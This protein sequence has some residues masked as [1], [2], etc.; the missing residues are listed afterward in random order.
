MPTRPVARKLPP[1]F[2]LTP[3]VSDALQ[4]HH[5]I[6]ALESTVVTHG[7]PHPEN[8]ALAR[9]METQVRE[10]GSIPAT[11]AVMEG[12]VRVGLTDTQLQ[13]LATAPHPRKIS[14]RDFAPALVQQAIGGTTVAG[15]LFAANQA[16]ICIFATGGIG[17]VHRFPAYDISTDLPLLASTPVVVVCAG[18]KAILDLPGTLEYLETVGVPVVGYQTDEFPAFYSQESGFPV[19]ARADSPEEI[20]AI[21]NTHWT[22]GFKSALLV[23]APPP[24]EIALPQSQVEGAIEQALEEAREKNVRGQAIT[25]FLLGRVSELTGK[26]SMKANLGLLH[27]NA[28]L[29]SQIAQFLY[30]G[31]YKAI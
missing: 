20:A 6:V 11:I 14:V 7:L 31:R 3:E 9:D 29:A 5:P 2:A 25:P 4:R 10:Q 28:R 24:A 18:A 19:S 16:G 30:T 17:G 13:T 27:N 21:A 12:K 1:S 23:T 15:T 26:A 22:L 8:L